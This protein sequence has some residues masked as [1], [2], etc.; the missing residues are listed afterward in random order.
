MLLPLL[1]NNLLSEAGVPAP[2]LV[3][4]TPAGSSR[5]RRLY[6]EIDG[7]HFEVRSTQEAQALL[8]RAKALARDAAEAVAERV[9]ARAEP[10][11]PIKPVSLKAP[12]VTASPELK[13]DLT[14]I[15]AQ[16]AKVYRDAETALE[17]RLLLKRQ[18]EIDEEESIFLLM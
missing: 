13:V 5:R 10:R 14:D 11:A 1:M 17:L 12:E 15:R 8:D 16:L 18:A 2:A 6:V 4:Q 3:T 7:N 9:E